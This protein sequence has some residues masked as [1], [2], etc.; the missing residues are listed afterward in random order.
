MSG[1]ST[2]SPFRPPSAGDAS[3]WLRSLRAATL[4]TPATLTGGQQ[5]GGDE[6]GSPLTAAPPVVP[7]GHRSLAELGARLLFE[8]VM[9]T[10][11]VSGH[12][13]IVISKVWLI[14]C[15]LIGPAR[16]FCMACSLNFRLLTRFATLPRECAMHRAWVGTEQQQAVSI[17]SG[18][19]LC[20]PGPCAHASIL[21]A[22]VD[23]GMTP[24][25]C[26][27]RAVQLAAAMSLPH[28]DESNGFALRLDVED[29]CGAS[30]ALMY[31]SWANGPKSRMWLLE[32]LRDVQAKY[33]IALGDVL[34]FRRVRRLLG[35]KTSVALGMAG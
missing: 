6:T 11:D 30:H 25:C 22:T 23:D 19:P 5:S 35:P 15:R 29:T 31:R 20:R 14:A 27:R 24:T 12:G 16:S 26:R 9:T 7:P 34:M 10:C 21:P 2:C 1:A 3:L 32:G 8:K 18:S 33:G 4:N 17:R 13:R 28:L